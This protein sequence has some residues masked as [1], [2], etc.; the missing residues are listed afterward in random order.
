MNDMASIRKMGPGPVE[1]RGNGLD[2][3]VAHSS[4]GVVG[5]FSA[6]AFFGGNRLS[7][8]G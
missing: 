8:S 3:A 6:D 7:L 4:V 2:D 1:E 5:T